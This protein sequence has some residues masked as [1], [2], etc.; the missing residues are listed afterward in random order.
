ML[1]AQY[2]IGFRPTN[3]MKVALQ[4]NILQYIV[5]YVF[6]WYPTALML[7]A[8]LPTEIAPASKDSARPFD[9]GLSLSCIYLE[10]GEGTVT[11]N[12]QCMRDRCYLSDQSHQHVIYTV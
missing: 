10:T 7:P 1:V 11:A 8:Q 4:N 9:H 3:Q 12:I 5:L 2:C 6:P